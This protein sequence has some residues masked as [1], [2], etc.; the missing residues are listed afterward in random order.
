MTLES[1]KGSKRM[2]WA[3]EVEL[4]VQP[5]NKG[6]V[7]RMNKSGVELFKSGPGESTKGKVY[8]CTLSRLMKILSLLSRLMSRVK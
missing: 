2:S 7:S 5:E 8:C 1:G 3:D 6:I 4:D